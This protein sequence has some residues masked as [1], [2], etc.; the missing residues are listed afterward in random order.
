MNVYFLK[1]VS[2]LINLLL[3]GALFWLPGVPA[4]AEQGSVLSY[5]EAITLIEYGNSNQQMDGV[6]AVVL[7]GDKRAGAVL[8]K[9]F[10]DPNTEGMVKISVAYALGLLGVESAQDVLI[11]AL[12]QDMVRRTGVWSGIIPAL[13]EL[14]S[15]SAIPILLKALKKRDDRWLGREMAATALGHIGSQEA[16]PGLMTAAMMVDTRESA[17]GAL[18]AIGDSRAAQVFL[19]ALQDGEEQEIVKLATDGLR[20]LGDAAVPGMI[21]EFERYNREFPETMKRLMLCQLL[22]ENGS[23]QAY[24]S[25]KRVATD[26]RDGWVLK[27]AKQQLSRKK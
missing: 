19:D 26:R 27:C 6:D 2:R 7:L 8:M 21:R 25:L 13:G 3:I 16:V 14:R 5:E 11:P 17:M 12:E 22:G 15:K 20:N 23:K 18:A 9:V 10:E 24:A 4:N 1:P